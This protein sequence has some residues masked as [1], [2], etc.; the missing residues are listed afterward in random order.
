MVGRGPAHCQVAAEPAAVDLA[1]DEQASGILGEDGAQN[2][3]VALSRRFCDTETSSVRR[4]DLP[5]Q[6][7]GAPFVPK[8]RQAMIVEQLTIHRGQ[9]R[10]SRPRTSSTGRCG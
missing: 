4:I 10:L 9:N 1:T 2:L 8:E 6:G 3:V 7:A 5:E